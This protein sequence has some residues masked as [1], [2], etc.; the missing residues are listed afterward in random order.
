MQAISPVLRAAAHRACGLPCVSGVHDTDP[1]T[2]GHAQTASASDRQARHPAQRPP[3][4]AQG[5]VPEMTFEDMNFEDTRFAP[6]DEYRV[7]PDGTVQE[8]S[9]PPYS[10]LSDD[11]LTVHAEDE[12][13]ALA[14]VDRAYPRE[15]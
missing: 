11:Y 2:A 13:A 6:L 9:E 12:A 14:K 8:A 4:A 1:A 15:A 5:G 3:S 7:W 10:W